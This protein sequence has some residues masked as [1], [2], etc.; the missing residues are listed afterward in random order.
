MGVLFEFD[1]VW[2]RHDH[3]DVLA[4]VTASID[5][6][7][8]TA[9]V[10]PSGSGKS[11]LLRCGN[12]LEV[13]T[14]GVV[15]YRGRDVNQLDPLL[16]RRR[17]AMV[18]QTPTTFPGSALDNLRVADPSLTDDRAL[19]LLDR[20]GLDPA[21]ADRTADRLSGGEAQRLVIARALA[22]GPE[23]LLADEPT[24]ALDAAAV[25]HL[26]R[27]VRS[28]ADAGTPVLWVSHDRAQVR[29]LADH[30]V[31]LRGGRVEW[32]GDKSQLE[33]IPGSNDAE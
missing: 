14:A 29:R 6:E 24:S 12:R 25:A 32:A 2:V 31:A 22:A 21:L 20:V 13:P 26:E 33:L 27:L 11:T 30:V 7:G 10:G 4:G 1:D 18:F 15:R 5:D 9:I 8:I 16:H 3:T 19:A 23:V 28:L 17:V